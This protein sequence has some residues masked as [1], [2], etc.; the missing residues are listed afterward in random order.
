MDFIFIVLN[1]NSIV[2]RSR[3]QDFELLLKE[4]IPQARPDSTTATGLF[5]LIKFLSNRSLRTATTHKCQYVL[6]T[7][8]YFP[9]EFF[10]SFVVTLISQDTVFTMV[11][12]VAIY[13]PNQSF[14]SSNLPNLIYFCPSQPRG[15]AK[16]WSLVE[17]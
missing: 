5:S 13:C 12:N 4:R 9:V 7:Q 11:Y 1:I 10:K 16:P 15:E 2:G 14:D 17:A 8:H 3:R 6:S